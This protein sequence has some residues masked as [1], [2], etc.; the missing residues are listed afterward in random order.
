M[1]VCVHMRMCTYAYTQPPKYCSN[2]IQ[3]FSALSLQFLLNFPTSIDLSNFSHSFP[4]SMILSNHIHSEKKFRPFR[5]PPPFPTYLKTSQLLQSLSNFICILQL[6]L[7]LQ[8]ELSNFILSNFMSN[9]SFF[10]TALSNY[11]YPVFE[12]INLTYMI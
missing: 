10:P 1:C 11:T 5:R 3:L 4:T 12:R 6:Q 2:H 9:F 7:E 8:R